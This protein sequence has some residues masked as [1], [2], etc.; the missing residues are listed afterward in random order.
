MCAVFVCVHTRDTVT[1]HMVQDTPL[2]QLSIHSTLYTLY[3]I[4]S[5]Y[6]LHPSEALH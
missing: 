3:A 2:I 4:H 6:A 1:Q 5:V